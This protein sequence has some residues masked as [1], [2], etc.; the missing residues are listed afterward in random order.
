MTSQQIKAILIFTGLGLIL[1]FSELH[2]QDISNINTMLNAEKRADSL[3]KTMSLREQIGQLFM[4]AAYSNRDSAHTREIETL[5]KEYHIGGLIFFQG[6]PIAQARLANFYQSVSDIPLWVAMDG[7]WGLGMR[8]DST[9][10]FPYQ[11]TLGAVN[12]NHLIY[13]MG[14]AIGR[15]F[16]RIGMHINYAPVLD[17]NNN[18]EN[19]VIN[20]RSFGDNKKNVAEK[21]MAYIRGLQDAGVLATGKHFPG[22]G[23]TH[24]DSHKDLPLLEHSWQRLDTMELYPFKESIRHGL[25]GIMVAH[26]NIPAL[27][28][29]EHV[30]STLS[31]K[32]VKGILR[33]SLG[34]DGLVFTD[35][36]GMEGVTK[37][38]KPGEIE[39][40]ALQADNDVLLFPQDMPLAVRRISDAVRNG[41]LKKSVIYQ[42]CKKILMAKHLLNVQ[43]NM[44]INISSLPEDI[45]SLDDRLLNRRLHLAAI[46][47]I[48]NTNNRLPL[49]RLDTLKIASLTIG[50]GK[51]GVFE[52]RLSQYTLVDHFTLAN[53]EIEARKDDILD[54][55]KN[56]N[57]VI[58][59]V[60]NLSK[61]AGHNYGITPALD[62]MIQD[63]TTSMPSILIWWGSPYGLARIDGF[64]RAEVIVITF[65][66]DEL[67]KD[68]AAQLVFGGTG[69]SGTLPVSVNTSYLSG[70]GINI[71]GG[72][73]FSYG[74]PEEAGLNGGY[75]NKKIDS[76]ARIALKN[77]VAPGLQVLIAR[78]QKVVLHKMYG[79]HT[80]DSLLKVTDTDIYDLASV[81]KIT[82][83]LPALM[84]L[85]DQGK[86]SL[87]A[88]PGDY[89]EYFEKGNKKDLMFRRILSHNA[90]LEAW[91]PYWKTTL[92]NNG[93]F[94]RKTLSHDSSALYRIRLT[95]NLYLYK[96]YKQKIYK[97]IRKSKLLPEEGYVYSGLSFYLYPEIVEKLTGEDF[98][99]HLKNTF[100]KPLGANTITY[101]PLT[102]F[103][104][105]RIIPTE[106]DTFFR[107]ELLHGIVHDEGAAMMNGVSSNAGLFT[108]AGDLAKLM[109]MYMNMGTYGGER[110][111]SSNTLEKFTFCHFCEEGN[112]RGLAFDKP[113]L[114]NKAEGST[115]IDASHLSFGHSGYTGT[116]VWA[117]PD[118]GILFIFLSNRVHPTRENRKLYQLNIRPAMHQAIYDARFY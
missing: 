107:K 89:L 95:D 6:S 118:T 27:D 106:V 28:R 56:Y 75:L 40:M 85:H 52:K 110:F 21:G 103:S 25:S 32:I 39:L 45:N 62:Q 14:L 109:Q 104:L 108:S 102:Y 17:I 48:K 38:F 69:A 41:E 24:V 88:T 50:S 113:V 8:L 20:F 49:M 99:T 64:D 22:H 42:K 105:D 46:T 91:I 55:L 61:W 81:T 83:A 53:D 31:K 35:A 13:K 111:I 5:I 1:N 87:E 116:F 57:L 63:V 11:M 70:Y 58:L 9:M 117:D 33:D 15:Q 51:S 115:A 29:S 97:M 67:M 26:L 90:R 74:L 37:Y 86:F 77:G 73:R 2:G 112:R 96:D 34:F 84:R 3:L 7:E 10:S 100:Y 12:D 23:D 93:K 94:I 47:V 79:Y 43:E 19:P 72:V 71:D 82:G 36:L 4:V 16:R 114:E 60:D 54:S 80:Y 30:P 78:H 66:E 76:I 18:A 59:G 68:F 98:E 92:K 65:Q 101:N 44:I